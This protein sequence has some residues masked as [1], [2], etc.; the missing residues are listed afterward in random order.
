MIEGHIGIDETNDHSLLTGER[1]K[2]II[3]TILVV[4]SFLIIASV[5]V[6]CY[7]CKIRVRDPI[8]LRQCARIEIIDS[9]SKCHISKTVTSGGNP[10][11]VCTPDG[12]VRLTPGVVT[13]ARPNT[14]FIADFES[15]LHESNT[16]T[17]EVISE[18]VME[19]GDDD[20]YHEDLYQT[21][22]MTQTT[23]ESEEDHSFDALYRMDAIDG[24]TVSKGMTD[25]NVHNITE[26]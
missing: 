3:Y 14:M 5:F 24:N 7:Y 13:C 21:Q 12:M 22:G 1:M 11:D 15:T 2:C 18:R 23:G 19:S 6:T 10:L 16:C 8:K 25:G 4:F 26:H 9:V 17:P 20:C